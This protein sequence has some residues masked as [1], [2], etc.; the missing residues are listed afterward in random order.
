[1]ADFFGGSCA[2]GAPPESKLCQQCVGS[3]DSNDERVRNATKCKPS[4]DE[5]YKGGKGAVK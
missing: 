4:A 1:M 2:P 3:I 5:A